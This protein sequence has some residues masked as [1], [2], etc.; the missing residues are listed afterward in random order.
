MMDKN[1]QVKLLEKLTCF[2]ICSESDGEI[3]V[4]YKRWYWFDFE[5]V[6]G[7]G[8]RAEI[9]DACRKI[10]D[11][12]VKAEK[13]SEEMFAQNLYTVGMPDV[14]LMVRTGGAMRVSNFLPWQLSYAEMFFVDKYWPE[15]TKHE[16]RKVLN[17]FEERERRFG[18]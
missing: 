11:T 14:D 3:V 4:R 13:L 8:G 5:F 1:V 7:Y 10:L 12:G 9:V 18:K 2:R 15:F 6:F 16:L 17:E